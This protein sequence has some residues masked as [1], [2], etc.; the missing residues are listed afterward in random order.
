M[1]VENFD[2]AYKHKANG[3]GYN[4]KDGDWIDAYTLSGEKGYK[5]NKVSFKILGRTS[6][7][8]LIARDK[9]S[10]ERFTLCPLNGDSAKSY[11]LHNKWTLSTVYLT[12]TAVYNAACDRLMKVKKN[13]NKS[14]HELNQ[15]IIDK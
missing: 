5:I 1:N 14:F 6:A 9:R 8:Y 7:E 11:N 2:E 3:D 13:I 4:E 10:L 15:F 12:K